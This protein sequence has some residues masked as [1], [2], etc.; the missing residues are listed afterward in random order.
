MMYNQRIPKTAT[1]NLY[2]IA[3]MIVKFISLYGVYHDEEGV[4]HRHEVARPQDL[5]TLA[6]LAK[7]VGAACDATLQ[8]QE[9]HRQA[10]P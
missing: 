1:I 3:R 5:N 10:R 7:K 2:A 4:A 9:A 6:G 8:L